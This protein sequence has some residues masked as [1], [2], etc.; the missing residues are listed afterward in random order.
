M[1]LYHFSDSGDITVFEPRAP[2]RR[3]DTAPLVYAID[4]WHSPLYFF[5]RDCPRVGIWP[6][7]STVD[8]E[9]RDFGGPRMR[10]LI[11]RRYEDKW[12][13][14]GIYRYTVDAAGFEDCRDHGV[15][16]CSHTATPERVEHLPD[17][18][19]AVEDAGVAVEIVDSLVDVGLSLF[20]RDEGRFTTTLHVSMIRMS[21]LAGWPEPTVPNVPRRGAQ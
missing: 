13:S 17:L 20:D 16:V 21:L 1:K 6:V 5:P 10:L 3:P 8:E 9:R 4:E 15:W 11:D 14:G 7:E 2:T 19:R 12:R 18:P